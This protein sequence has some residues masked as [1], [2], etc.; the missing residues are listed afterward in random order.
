VIDERAPIRGPVG[1]ASDASLK[2]A[3]EL[4]AR[5]GE[6]VKEAR[7]DGIRPLAIERLL[8]FLGYDMNALNVGRVEAADEAAIRRITAPKTPTDKPAAIPSASA[9]AEETKDEPK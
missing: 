1:R 4:E 7:L 6:V 2:R 8:N 9:K 3:S 5:M